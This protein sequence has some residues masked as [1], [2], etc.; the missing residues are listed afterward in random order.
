MDAQ[1]ITQTKNPFLEREEITLQIT[2]E[3]TPT[4]DEVK[5]AI[6]KDPT[7]TVIKKINT[8]FGQKIFQAKAVVYDT[9]EAKKRI[10]TI[11][12]KTRK[13]IEAEKKSTAETA[14]KAEAEAKA[15]EAT[16][17]KETPAE[18][19]PEDKTELK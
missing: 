12:R 17:A 13:K 19:K 4:S 10:E 9:P 6:G 18:N 2:N 3:T 15:T 11:P 1:I 7:L 16:P 5:S 14:K 8:N